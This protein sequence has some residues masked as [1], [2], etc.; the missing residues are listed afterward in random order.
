MGCFVS[1]FY[2][3]IVVTFGAVPPSLSNTDSHTFPQSSLSRS[4]LLSH[5]AV[6]VLLL[7]GILL[8]SRPTNRC[9]SEPG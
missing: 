8:S 4:L 6:L 3:V 2:D 9:T 7:P 5:C 1:M